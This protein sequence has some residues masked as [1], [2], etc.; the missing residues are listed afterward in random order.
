[1]KK[2]IKK[3]KFKSFKILNE[4]FKF[5]KSISISKLISSRPIFLEVLELSLNYGGMNVMCIYPRVQ[6]DSITLMHL[7]TIKYNLQIKLNI[8][9]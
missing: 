3:K 5:V 9:I 6:W 7:G 2:S 1:M 8:L 4:K